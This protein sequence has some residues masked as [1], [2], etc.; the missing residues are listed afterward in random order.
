M[1]ALGHKQ[2]VAI[3]SSERLLWRFIQ[4]PSR[5][6]EDKTGSYASESSKG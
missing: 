1:A 3:I 5:I 6:T 2:P 4:S